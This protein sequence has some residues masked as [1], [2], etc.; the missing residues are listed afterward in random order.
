MDRHRSRSLGNNAAI[1][2]R[3]L[4]AQINEAAKT[5][6]ARAVGQ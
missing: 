2:R 5:S 4:T 3:V 1:A 6:A